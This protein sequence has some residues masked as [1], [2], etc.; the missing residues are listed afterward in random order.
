[1]TRNRGKPKSTI[2]WGFVRWASTRHCFDLEKGIEK[3]ICGKDFAGELVFDVSRDNFKRREC[4]R[5]LNILKKKEQKK[6][7]ITCKVNRR[8]VNYKKVGTK[9][10]RCQM[11][12]SVGAEVPVFRVSTQKVEKG[13][14]I[15]VETD[16]AGLENDVY[17]VRFPSEAETSPGNLTSGW[18]TA[19]EIENIIEVSTKAPK[20]TRRKK[21]ASRLPRRYTMTVLNAQTGD[22]VTEFVDT[23][24]MADAILDAHQHVKD[25]GKF[26]VTIQEWKPSKNDKK[27]IIENS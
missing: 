11:D 18:Y 16:D 22:S 21:M 25:K 19:E 5:C 14:I 26:E 15:D 20:E 24:N 3:S 1:M 8:K 7:E 27:F 13:K 10:K 4:K 12:L 2:L 23:D 6:D 9:N 17:L